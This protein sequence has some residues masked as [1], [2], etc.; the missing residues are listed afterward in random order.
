MRRGAAERHP[1]EGFVLKRT[2]RFLALVLCAALALSGCRIA[3]P[4]TALTVDGVEIPAGLYLAFQLQ[5]YTE[6]QSKLTS[7]A[8]AD[9]SASVLTAE[10]EGVSGA[11]WIHKR[12]V[13]QA[14]NYVYLLRAYQDGGFSLTEEEQATI[15]DTVDSSWDSNS[16][17]CEANGIGYDT[18]SEYYMN[19]VRYQ[20]LYDKYNEEHADAVSD[21]DA[22][23]YMNETY[24]HVTAVTLPVTKA[25][26]TTVE[27]ADLETIKG[28]AEDL[29]DALAKGD[30]TM[31]E[32][33][34]DTLKKVFALE[35][36]DYTDDA[37]S[38]Y[39]VDTYVRAESTTF[40]TDLIAE[41]MAAKAGDAGLYM[42]SS[43]PVVYVKTANYEDDTEFAQYRDTM[44]SAITQSEFDDEMNKA[45]E[46][47][48]VQ[49]NASAIR[50]YAPKKIV[51]SVAQ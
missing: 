31:E 19:G 26:G 21:A 8:S 5:A 11:D 49:E 22:K 43:K 48:E 46:A 51:N 6:A 25:D 13:D 23:A 9:A 3:T 37:L 44:V 15:Q 33:L 40:P 45:C 24:S 50:S 2:V 20:T 10:I 16:A 27:D 34:P 39:L 35:G 38:S 41:M 47:Y 42:L 18:Y 7:S 1:L 30:K 32:L 14:R 28:Y 4:S 12:T 29:K 17:Y 36:R